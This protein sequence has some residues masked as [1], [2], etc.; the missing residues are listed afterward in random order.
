VEQ[1]C[2]VAVVVVAVVVV[3]LVVVVVSTYTEEK[4]IF[5][6]FYRILLKLDKWNSEPLVESVMVATLSGKMAAKR[7]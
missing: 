2:V 7:K 5:L 1:K 4:F 6:L 3:M